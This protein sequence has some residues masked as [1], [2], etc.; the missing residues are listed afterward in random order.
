MK[1]LAIFCYLVIILRGSMIGIPFFLWLL[2]S[3]SEFGELSQLFAICAAL[4]LVGYFP[5]F[6]GYDFRRIGL[7]R[8]ISILLLLSPLLWRMTVVPITSFDYTGFILP[9]TVFIVL[10]IITTVFEIKQAYTME[11]SKQL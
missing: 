6:S 3:L 2:V 4:G 9:F 1:W 5:K 11:S 8:I 10:S 7:L